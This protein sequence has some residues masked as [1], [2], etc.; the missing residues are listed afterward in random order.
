MYEDF[1]GFDFYLPKSITEIPVFDT[2]E[3]NNQFTEFLDFEIDSWFVKKE[4]YVDR[5][6]HI[7]VVSED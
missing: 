5:Y 3:T 1:Q 4:G 2:D 7:I 6:P